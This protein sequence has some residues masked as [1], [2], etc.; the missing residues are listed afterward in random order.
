MFARTVSLQAITTCNGIFSVRS[1]LAQA[2]P[3][4]EFPPVIIT[5]CNEDEPVFDFIFCLFINHFFCLG[6]IA[7]IARDKFSQK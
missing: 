4:P 3:N 7:T 5:V 1:V 2:S 6:K